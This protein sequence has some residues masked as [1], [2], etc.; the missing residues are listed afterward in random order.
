MTRMLRALSNADATT[1]ESRA[2]ALQ[3]ARLVTGTV[4]PHPEDAE[5]F[6][7]IIL[8]IARGAER[9]TEMTRAR[10]EVEPPRIC[11]AV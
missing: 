11:R 4:R 2:A 10:R 8:D 5:Q 6:E 7:Q 1:A 9:L 3:F